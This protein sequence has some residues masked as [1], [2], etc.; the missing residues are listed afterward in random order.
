MMINKRLP[1]LA[2]SFIGSVHFFVL[3]LTIAI[4]APNG[5]NIFWVLLSIWIPFSAVSIVA[6]LYAVFS[7]NS[8]LQFIKNIKQDDYR[9][10]LRNVIKYFDTL[11]LKKVYDYKSFN[12][13][14]IFICNL[15]SSKKSIFGQRKSFPVEYMNDSNSIEKKKF[16]YISYKNRLNSVVDKFMIFHEIAHYQ[17]GGPST[18]FTSFMPLSTVIFGL[19]LWLIGVYEIINESDSIIYFVMLFF[20]SCLSTVRGTFKDMRLEN[21]CDGQAYMNCKKIMSKTELDR[22]DKALSFLLP[23]D[24]LSELINV[25]DKGEDSFTD[26]QLILNT[27]LI[28]VLVELFILCVLIVLIAINIISIDYW[29]LFTVSISM[30]LLF[31]IATLLIDWLQNKV[32]DEITKLQDLTD[33]PVSKRNVTIMVEANIDSIRNK[34]ELVSELLLLSRAQGID[35]IGELLSKVNKDTEIRKFLKL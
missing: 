27:P 2:A 29:R 34:S 1:I 18:R 13:N 7:Y 33:L 16:I 14:K 8:H 24:R 17:F 12:E 11:E 5:I 26:E 19:I 9:V 21:L 28:G 15:I 20:L 3:H 35:R 10:I 30:L 6:V 25:K 22:L 23:K 32:E 31:Y 4:I